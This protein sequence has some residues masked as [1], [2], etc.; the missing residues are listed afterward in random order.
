MERQFG[1]YRLVRQVAVGGMAEIHLA[2]T[3]GIA[4][5]EFKRNPF[6]YRTIAPLESKHHAFG[7]Q[8]SLGRR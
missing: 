7:T 3:K 2:K 4:G 5:F 8:P 1:P 6:E